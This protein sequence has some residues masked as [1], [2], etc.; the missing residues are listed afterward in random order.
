MIHSI[1]KHVFALLV[2]SIMLAACSNQPQG[3]PNGIVLNIE[4][5]GMA[6]NTEMIIMLGATQQPEDPIQKV[7]VMGG[8]AQFAFDV[9]GPRIYDIMVPDSYGLMQV[10]MDK[11]QVATLSVQVTSKVEDDKKTSYRYTDM[12]VTGQSLQ[13]EFV[14]R[15]VDRN[16][17]DERYEAMHKIT[18]KDEFE[19]AQA[20]F[21][22][23]VETSYKDS[24][25][26][27]ADSW[28]GAMLILNCYTYITSEQEADYNILSAAAKQSFYGKILHDKIW[29]PSIIG[30]EVLDFEFTDYATQ[31][32]TSLY[33]CLEGKKYLLID[34][35]A[36]WCKPCRKEIPN[37][38]EQYKKWADN[39][40]EVV[41]IS[42][43]KDEA[44]W[45]KAL[46]DEQL[47]WPND[48]DGK[49]GIAN[50]Y[51]V[52]YYPT[53]Y[54]IDSNHKVI[55]KDI[56]GEELANKLAELFK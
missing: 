23:L 48:I 19:K 13:D 31:K 45:L 8:K 17:L 10:V 35:W 14:K 33:K 5:A 36:S 28:W 16:A 42:A 2:A 39:G 7:T 30:Q 47:P 43:D 50:K 11:G 40:F 15:S 49:Q 46:K 21:F 4:A 29:P 25:K 18:D 56:K 55:A 27:N 32:R 20:E 37:I 44:A 34:F 53:L 12:K 24:F 54:L 1:I 3:N 26:A 22:K 41:S 9:E 6:D 52:T 51:K 38:K